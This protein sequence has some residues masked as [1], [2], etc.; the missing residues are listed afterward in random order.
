MVSFNC[1]GN[2]S[3]TFEVLETVT[4]AM[5][6]MILTRD[7]FLKFATFTGEKWVGGLINHDQLSMSLGYKIYY[8]GTPGAVLEQ[9]GLPQLPVQHVTMH[10]GWTWIGHAPLHAYSLD[11]IAPII[12]NFSADDQVKTRTGASVDPLEFSTFDGEHWQGS[13]VQLTPGIGYEF[14]VAQAVTFCYGDLCG[15]PN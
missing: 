9:K 14:K 8:S 12:G 1:I 3:N 11:Q 5:D 2:M 7:P 15:T 4:W 10:R 13:L 6:D